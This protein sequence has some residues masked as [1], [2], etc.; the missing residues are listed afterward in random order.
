MEVFTEVE[1]LVEV[2]NVLSAFEGFEASFERTV[3]D[4][5]IGCKTFGTPN[6]STLKISPSMAAHEGE[7]SSAARK[8][9]IEFL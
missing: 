6:G 3:G 7:H 9:N 5:S 4:G 2:V 8:N 1:G